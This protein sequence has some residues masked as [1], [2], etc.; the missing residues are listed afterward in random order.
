MYV[1]V[2]EIK[3]DCI[4]WLINWIICIIDSIFNLVICLFGRMRISLYLYLLINIY[5][6]N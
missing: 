5:Y 4:V 1:C 3:K 6:V 2:D